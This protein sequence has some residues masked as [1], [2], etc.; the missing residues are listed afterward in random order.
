MV[1]DT[2]RHAVHFWVSLVPKTR[3]SNEPQKRHHWKAA[4]ADRRGRFAHAFFEWKDQDR[5]FRRSKDWT[6]R[7]HGRALLDFHGRRPVIEW[8]TADKSRLKWQLQRHQDQFSPRR[9]E[10]LR[11]RLHLRF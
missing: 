1:Q 7:D 8:N 11:Q 4:R 5:F 6:A 3:R 2:L 9:V 10:E